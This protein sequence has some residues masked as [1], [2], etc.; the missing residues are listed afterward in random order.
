MNYSDLTRDLVKKCLQRG[1]D[2]AE[3]Y[4]QDG[5]NLRIEVRNGNVETVNESAGH[6][7]GLRVFIKGKMAFASCNDFSESA[8][9]DA[10]N[11]AVA[12]AASTTADENN[13]LPDDKTV[14]SVEGL[15]DAEIGRIAMDEKIN[16]LLALE[17]AAMQDSRITKSAGGRY[18]ETETYIYLANSNGLAKDYK[19]STCYFGVS[20]VAEKGEQ[21]SSGGE[22]CVRRFWNDLK[23]VQ[24]IAA[25]A[26]KSAYEM[27]DPRM[28]KTQ[29][30][31]VI[32]DPDVAYA[33]LSGIEAAVSGERVL[34]GASFL[35]DRLNKK[36]ASDLLT[37]IDD[38]LLPKG[39]ASE[40]FDGEGVATQ[41]RF[42]VQNGVLQ[43]FMYNSIVAKRAGIKS[44]GNASR[45]DFSGLPEIGSHNFYLAAG[46]HKPQEIFAATRTGLHVK[47]ITGYGIN[48]VNGNF[49]GGASGFWVENGKIAFPVRGLTIA[50]NAF[51]MLN[52]IDMV[53]DDL[54]LADGKSSPTFRIKS[55]QIGG[56]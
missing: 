17:K 27:L 23:P 40:P 2:S 28:I 47:E 24:E 49:S 36:I 48:P 41:K 7:V 20:V 4:L 13:C 8:L 51:A 38:G 11:R 53:G 10:A 37:I 19:R 29:K 56:E 5:R 1:A 26:A 31:A 30:A 18:G 34:Q 42:I 9:T 46:K 25:K 50:G 52:D 3:V 35:G 33:I 39:M 54:D 43:G 6:G 22:Y 21:K 12:F 55:M 45:G 14:S 16:R 44:T 15:Y 32:F